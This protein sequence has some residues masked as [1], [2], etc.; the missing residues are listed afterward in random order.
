MNRGRFR[1]SVALC[2]RT[3]RGLRALFRSGWDPFEPIGVAELA[4]GNV[5]DLLHVAVEM[6]QAVPDRGQDGFI[7]TLNATRCEKLRGGPR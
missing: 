3:L 7:E 4:A 6:G 2:A 5:N 1:F